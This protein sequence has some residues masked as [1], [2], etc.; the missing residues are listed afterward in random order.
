MTPEMAL[1]LS[2][3]FRTEPSLLLTLQ[4]DVD[5]WD[6]RQKLKAELAKIEPAEWDREEI[7]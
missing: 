1:R 2:T 7:G 5:L 6:A 3:Y 4:T